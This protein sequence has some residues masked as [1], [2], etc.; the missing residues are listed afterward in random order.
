[1]TLKKNIKFKSYFMCSY[2]SFLTIISM[3]CSKC[4]KVIQPQIKYEPGS[5]D[6]KA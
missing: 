3:K 1:M 2:A 4:L 6:F 5:I